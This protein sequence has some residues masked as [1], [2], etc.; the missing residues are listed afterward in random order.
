LF[1][2]SGSASRA[3]R[4]SRPPWP[5]S[6]RRR[7][8]A[9][10]PPP[11]FRAGLAHQGQDDGYQAARPRRDGTPGWRTQP[12]AEAISPLAIPRASCLD[13]G[14]RI[15]PAHPRARHGCASALP[16]RRLHRR[17]PASSTPSILARSSF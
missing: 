17:S 11:A 15:E 6:R 5:A 14:R 4:L 3:E 12:Q 1:P 10:A 16:R 13:T 8:V 2:K 9:P 7:A